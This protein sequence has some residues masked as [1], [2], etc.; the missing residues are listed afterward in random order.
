MFDADIAAF[1]DNVCHGRLMDDLG[2][3]LDDARLRFLIR[4][5]L[6]GF[7]GEKGLAQGAP[8]SPLLSNLFLHP[9]D[10]VLLQCG[11]GL[12][13]YA[14]DFVVLTANRAG[15]I[16]ASRIA[17]GVLGRRGLSL[18]PTKTRVLP[19]AEGFVFL[20]EHIAGRGV[21]VGNRRCPPILPRKA[22]APSS[23][24]LT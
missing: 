1:F 24:K 15:A 7:G 19:I 12:V 10:Q 9:L 6:R 11:S 2:I 8:I 16:E 21:R 17:E 18:N 20:G 5:W 4:Q 13:R 22:R 14:D 23:L 3:W